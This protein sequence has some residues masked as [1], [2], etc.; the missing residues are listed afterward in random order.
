MQLPPATNWARARSGKTYLGDAQNQIDA[1][2]AD[3]YALHMDWG[4]SAVPAQDDPAP[5]MTLTPPDLEPPT[6]APVIDAFAV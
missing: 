4:A 6:P 5:T 2:D 3:V 1:D